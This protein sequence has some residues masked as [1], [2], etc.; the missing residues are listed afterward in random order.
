VTCRRELCSFRSRIA[1]P[2]SGGH[3]YTRTVGLSRRPTRW[4]VMIS[5]ARDSTTAHVWGDAATS[6]SR[7]RIRPLLKS[8]SNRWPRERREWPGTVRRQNRRHVFKNCTRRKSLA[9]ITSGNYFHAVPYGFHYTL[10]VWFYSSWHRR[11]PTRHASPPPPPVCFS[12]AADP[13]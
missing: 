9:A 5:T 3:V 7:F 12:R 6:F 10:P 4:N 11:H 1:K 8:L 13:S 2:C